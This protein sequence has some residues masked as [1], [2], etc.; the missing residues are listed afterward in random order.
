MVGSKLP[1]ENYSDVFQMEKC[2]ALGT[3]NGIGTL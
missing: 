2:C 1:V 3:E